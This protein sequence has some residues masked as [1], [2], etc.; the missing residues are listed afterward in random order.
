MNTSLQAHGGRHLAPAS[1]PYLWR[2]LV[3]AERADGWR[4]E[5]VFDDISER[6]A[7][8]TALEAVTDAWS[9]GV[10]AMHYVVGRVE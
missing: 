2:A 4:L 1:A 5:F 8:E 7:D 10:I 3:W 9:P 6:D